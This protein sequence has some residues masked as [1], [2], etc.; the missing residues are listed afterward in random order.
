MLGLV[1]NLKINYVIMLK[2]TLYDN[3]IEN[4]DFKWACKQEELGYWAWV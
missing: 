2:Y 4:K 1:N 3:A